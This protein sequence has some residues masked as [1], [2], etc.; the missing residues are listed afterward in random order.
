MKTETTEIFIGL[1]VNGKP[2][3][4]IND[5]KKAVANKFECKIDSYSIQ[6]IT[7]YYKGIEEKTLKITCIDANKSVLM[8]LVSQLRDELSQECIL[9]NTFN[10]EMS[11]I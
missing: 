8:L 3:H 9:I 4:K 2:F 1:N 6:V 7:G 5:A 11:L 10:S